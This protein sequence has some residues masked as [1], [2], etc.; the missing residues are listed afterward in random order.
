MNGSQ[1]LRFLETMRAAR[2]AGSRHRRALEE[3]I[4]LLWIWEEPFASVA[5]LVARD[6]FTS[7]RVSD[8]V[9]GLDDSGYVGVC[10]LGSRRNRQQRYFLKL[11]GVLSVRETFG[12]PLEWQVTQAGLERISRYTTFLEVAYRLAPRLW[13]STAAVPLRY[14]QSPDPDIDSEVAFDARAVMHRFIWVRNHAVHAV[15]EY[16]NPNGDFVAVPFVRFGSQHGPGAMGDGS[17]AGVF[18]GLVRPD[19]PAYT[20]P[21]ASPPGVVFLCA[22]ELAGLRVQNQFAPDIP[23]AVVISAGQVVETLR[24]VPPRKRF[25]MIERPARR[26]GA[27]DDIVRVVSGQS[28]RRCPESRGIGPHLPL[29]RVLSRQPD[30]PGVPGS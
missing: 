30:H 8:L 15:P 13:R 18:R 28:S 11:K 25:H 23:R 17:L 29:G 9:R 2:A 22:D 3:G 6:E 24:P 21:P 12:L 16:V 1:Y 14:G 27:P 7:Q 10:S 5:D 19:G 26:V 20:G 4:L